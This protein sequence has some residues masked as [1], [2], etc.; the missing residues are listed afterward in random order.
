MAGF[1]SSTEQAN[2]INDFATSF[3]TWSRN[4]TVYKEPLK[5]PVVNVGQGGNLFGFGEQQQNQTFTYTPVTGVFPAIIRY[6]DIKEDPE[7]DSI[8]SPEVMA[9]IYSGPVTIK[10]QRNCRDFLNNGLTDQVVIDGQMYYMN[11]DERLQT[12]QGSEYYIFSLRKT[13]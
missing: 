13:K 2:M 5:T 8:L 3:L 7:K 4:I 12:F 9:R 6:D 11:S 1:F 10:V